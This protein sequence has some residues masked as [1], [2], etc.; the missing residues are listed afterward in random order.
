MQNHAKQSPWIDVRQTASCNAVVS[1]EKQILMRI[2][3]GLCSCHSCT[4]PHVLK[5]MVVVC[6][7]VVFVVL[8]NE[9]RLAVSCQV[10]SSQLE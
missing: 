2:G 8:A 3:V 6:F 7:R 4:R 9:I 5:S 1:G 10:F